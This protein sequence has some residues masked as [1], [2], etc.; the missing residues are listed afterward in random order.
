MRSKGFISRLAWPFA[1]EIERTTSRGVAK[2]DYLQFSKSR[3]TE[4]GELPHGAIP[5]ALKVTRPVGYKILSNGVKVCTESWAG[6][7]TS[8]SMIIL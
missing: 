3:L 1:S 5:D 8:Y 2:R 7:L 6:P 4:F